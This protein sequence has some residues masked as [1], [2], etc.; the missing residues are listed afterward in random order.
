MYSNVVHWVSMSLVHREKA[1]TF[2]VRPKNTKALNLPHRESKK[3][4]SILSMHI[5]VIVIYST[6]TN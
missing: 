5:K 2:K 4:T 6:S 3:T 1:A